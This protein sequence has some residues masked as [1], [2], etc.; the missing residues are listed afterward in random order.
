MCVCVIYK[1]IHTHT[2]AGYELRGGYFVDDLNRDGCF[3]GALLYSGGYSTWVLQQGY[4][5]TTLRYAHA[6]EGVCVYVCVCVRVC[7]C[8]CICIC[9]CVYIYI[10][11][12]MHVCVHTYIHTH[13]QIYIHTHTYRL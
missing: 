4:A 11:I 10:Y 2:H 1:D 8:I 6:G 3:L 13:I 9:V 7:M 12:Y 5:L